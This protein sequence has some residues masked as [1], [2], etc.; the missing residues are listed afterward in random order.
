[1]EI[2]N[3]NSTLFHK[4]CYDFNSLKSILDDNGFKNVNKYNWRKT[5]HSEF[6]DHSQAYF[7]HMDKENGIL[8][9]LNIECQ[10]I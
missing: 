3:G 7:P 6:D 2:N 4:T 9:S 1:M 8:V 5:D 10:K